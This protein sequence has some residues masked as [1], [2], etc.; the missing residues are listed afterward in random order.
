[1]TTREAKPCHALSTAGS[2]AH[3]AAHHKSHSRAGGGSLQAMLTWLRRP[4][5]PLCKESCTH[6]SIILNLPQMHIFAAVLMHCHTLLLLHE[7]LPT[8]FFYN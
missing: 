1:M 5:L 4:P 8:P 7:C 3:G 2:A 6:A